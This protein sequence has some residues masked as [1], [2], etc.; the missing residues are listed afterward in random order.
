MPPAAGPETVRTI[1]VFDGE[2]VT[3]AGHDE[4][5]GK[6]T[7]ALVEPGRSLDLASAD[8]AD[9][10]VLQGR[11]IGEPVARYGPFVMNDEDE[12]R[13]A[14]TDYQA[15]QFGGWPWQGDDPNHGP[16]RARFALHADGREEHPP[17]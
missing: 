4:L 2:G 15:T 12:I 5:L 7:G 3:V 9:V 16:D 11:P 13:Q 8:G 10:L 17:E 6:F 1:Y 14:F